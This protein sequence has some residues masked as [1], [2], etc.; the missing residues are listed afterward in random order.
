MALQL[1]FSPS[2]YRCDWT[3]CVARYR[4]VKAVKLQRCQL[5]RSA[6]DASW[7]VT[8]RATT[9]RPARTIVR[10]SVLKAWIGTGIATRPVAGAPVSQ[11]QTADEWRNAFPPDRHCAVKPPP[12]WVGFVIGAPNHREQLR[13]SRT[14]QAVCRFKVS[15]FDTAQRSPHRSSPLQ[16]LWRGCNAPQ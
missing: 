9:R 13:K 2:L 7:R 4:L 14:A 15:C 1:G 12:T 16:C 8:W 6:L 11:R 3:M 10:P 5:D